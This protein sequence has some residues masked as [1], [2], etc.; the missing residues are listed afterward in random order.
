MWFDLK[1]SEIYQEWKGKLIVDWPP[2]ERSWTRWADRNDFRIKAILEESALDKGMPRWNELILTWE[3]L[4]HLPKSWIAVMSQWRGIYF[5]LDATDGRGYVGSAY[6]GENL[7]G[8]WSNYKAS[9]DG[10]NIRLRARVPDKFV[11][12][13]LERVSPDMRAEDV[14]QLEK[15]WKDRLHTREFGLNAN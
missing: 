1:L 8:R 6:G 5:V 4:A 12:S 15:N 9:G 10:G 11:F 3:Q 2:P 13:I 7:Y 14:I